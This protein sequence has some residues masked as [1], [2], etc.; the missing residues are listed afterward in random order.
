MPD[1]D[2]ER[3]QRDLDSLERRRPAR[4]DEHADGQ[5]YY[6]DKAAMASYGERQGLLHGIATL[7]EQGKRERQ[8]IGIARR[9]LGVPDD[10]HAALV[11]RIT[12]G[13]TSSTSDCG[14][15]ERAAILAEYRA[16][17]FKETKSRRAGRAP[18]RDAMDS[19]SMLKRVEQLLTVLKLPWRYAE[20]IIR[21]QR[22][23]TDK[24]VSCPAG[25][26]TDTELRALIAALYRLQQRRGGKT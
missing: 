25:A 19:Q 4:P 13:R 22:G 24:R 23:I 1:P 16:A 5:A 18:R 9:Q 6:Q 15:V 20:A 3:M 26:C 10:A 14:S 17:G 8:K 2:I 7:T 12:A 11:Q 21:Q